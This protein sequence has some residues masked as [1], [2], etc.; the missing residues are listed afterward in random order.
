MQLCLLIT[1]SNSY[2]EDKV[3]VAYTPFHN[4]FDKQYTLVFKHAN[5]QLRVAKGLYV[6]F[7]T[8]LFKNKKNG[9]GPVEINYRV[10]ASP[11]FSLLTSRL[12]H[13]DALLS[14]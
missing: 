4:E 9:L 1:V 5:H 3:C 10:S 7:Q 12:A 13:S 14:S 6:V 8:I 11:V 2:I